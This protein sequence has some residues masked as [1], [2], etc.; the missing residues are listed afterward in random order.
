MVELVAAGDTCLG[1]R[2]GLMAMGHALCR[3]VRQCW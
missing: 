1:A 3:P 2:D